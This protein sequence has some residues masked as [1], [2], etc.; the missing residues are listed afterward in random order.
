MKRGFWTGFLAFIIAKI[1]HLI[2]TGA[3][4][5][6]L[7]TI[8]GDK[9]IS[10]DIIN[11][12]DSPLFGIVF[13]IFATAFIYK[14]LTKN[15]K[16]TKESQIG[17][18]SSLSSEDLEQITEDVNESARLAQALAESGDTVLMSSACASFDLFKNYI[19][20]GNQFKEAVFQL[21]MDN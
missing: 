1:F 21:T 8:I 10:W 12:I 16:S 7:V 15:K 2:I 17:N 5:L 3:I 9:P 4:G 11:F 13:L 18:K 14:K 6:I 20:R 19:D